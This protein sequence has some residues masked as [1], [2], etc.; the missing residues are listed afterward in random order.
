MNNRE[1]RSGELPGLSWQSRRGWPGLSGG[2]AVPSSQQKGG[3]S[4]KILHLLYNPL[5]LKGKDY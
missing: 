2:W 5:V 3:E 4:R 1:A